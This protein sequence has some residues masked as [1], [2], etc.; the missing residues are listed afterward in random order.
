MHATGLLRIN[1]VH[2]YI[3]CHV[4][5]AGDLK[6]G[7]ADTMRQSAGM[8]LSFHLPSL[9]PS[10]PPSFLSLFHSFAPSQPLCVD[11][12]GVYIQVSVT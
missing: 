6:E 8:S 4:I 5:F 2:V 1:V 3:L 11:E 9:P 12:H 10:F 7:V